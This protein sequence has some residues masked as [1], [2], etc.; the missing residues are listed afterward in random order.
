[1]DTS[2]GNVA[3]SAARNGPLIFAGILIFLGF[4]F[5]LQN[6]LHIDLGQLWPVILIVAGLALLIPAMRKP[7]A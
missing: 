4:W 6:L 5:L 3:Q 2:S 7:S 1:V